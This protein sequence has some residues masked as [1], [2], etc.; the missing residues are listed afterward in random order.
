[1]IEIKECFKLFSE[2]LKNGELS[3]DD[4]YW[5]FI[6]SSSN[7]FQE[8]E[9]IFNEVELEIID[10]DED[11]RIIWF[12]ENHLI[13]I[14]D[15]IEE[16]FNKVNHSYTVPPFFY[17]LSQTQD[18]QELFQ[19]YLSLKVYV[20]SKKVLA[21]LADHCEPKSGLAKGSDGLVFII[22]S[23]EKV[24]KHDF[25]PVTNWGFLNSID[26]E[27]EDY[28]ALENLSEILNLSEDPR[29]KERKY[30]LKA[31]LKDFIIDKCVSNEKVFETFLGSTKEFY[32]AYK[33]AHEIYINN[34]SISKILREI[35]EKDLEYTGKINDV[36]S[37]AQTKALTM[38]GVMVVIGAAL[39]VDSISDIILITLGVIFIASILI[40]SLSIFEATI[41]HL[42][43][44]VISD[45]DRY[46]S[47][48]YELDIRKKAETAKTE[49]NSLLDTGVH[50]SRHMKTL[51]KV[52]LIIML[53]YLVYIALTMCFL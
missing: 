20:E 40:K 33:Q 49:L 3:E 35:S 48:T 15:T 37:S 47:L 34:F 39:K 25:K 53:I 51:S 19:Q 18:S 16:I 7:S 13:W 22:E 28:K 50:N 27:E 24:T 5:K 14:A 1:M 21:K 10:S 30:V 8:I 23:Q 9:D 11:A 12:R 44:Q 29:E 45:F 26:F 43:K 4:N 38:P 36:V 42:K 52:A 2:L 46:N 32:I 41:S 17:V 6:F 31:T